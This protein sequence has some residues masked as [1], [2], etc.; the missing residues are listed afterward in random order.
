MCLLLSACSVIRPM[1]ESARNDYK[2]RTSWHRATGAA[3][4]SV[5]VIHGLNNRPESME[6]LIGLLND[7]NADA[8]LLTLRGHDGGTTELAAIKAEDWT[9]DIAQSM[10]QLA[11]EGRGGRRG[12]LAFSIGGVAA[13]EYLREHGNK[14]AGIDNAVLIAPPLALSL[15]STLIRMMLPG[16]Y[17]DLALPSLTPEAYRAHS[18]TPLA[19]YDAAFEL[20]RRVSSDPGPALRTLP[21]LILVSP[22]DEMVSIAG[23]R[24]LIETKALGAWRIEEVRPQPQ[25]QPSYSHLILD[26]PSMGAAEWRRISQIIS[27]EFDCR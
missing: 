7:N 27:K 18:H 23:L 11:A 25:F 12:L 24:R 6:P 5:L 21:A 4:A 14:A 26:P 13:L 8:L 3:C 9:A 19:A 20:I 2:T 10:T 22:D 17:L 1:P 16:R 15:R